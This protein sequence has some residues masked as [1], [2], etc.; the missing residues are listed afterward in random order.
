[1]GMSAGV[2]ARGIKVHAGG[3]FRVVSPF[4]VPAVFKTL[5]DAQRARALILKA[6]VSLLR[7]GHVKKV[8]EGLFL[9]RLE[10]WRKPRV[11]LSLKDAKRALGAAPRAAQETIEDKEGPLIDCPPALDGD[12]PCLFSLSKDRL[13]SLE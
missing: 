10:T 5:K 4:Y 13:C 8:G 12:W 2:Y 6:K 7:D 3:R 1:M 9:A 11:F